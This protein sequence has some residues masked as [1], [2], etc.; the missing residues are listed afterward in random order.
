MQFEALDHTMRVY[1]TAHAH[2]HP[3]R[4]LG[5]SLCQ[6]CEVTLHDRPRR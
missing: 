6:P 1:E 5:R 4:V 3:A 2:R